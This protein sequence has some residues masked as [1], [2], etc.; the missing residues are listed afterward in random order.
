MWRLWFETQIMLTREQRQQILGVCLL[1]LAL[2]VFLSLLPDSWFGGGD[3]WNPMG[4]IG[5]TL[6]DILHALIGHSGFLLPILLLF[7][8]LHIGEWIQEEW[9]VRLSVRTAV[10]DYP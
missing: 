10:A 9:T 2:F 8:G 3:E 4:I 5:W 7:M 6:G 1:A